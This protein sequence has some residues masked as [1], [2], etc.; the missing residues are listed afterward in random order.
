MKKDMRD[1]QQ[2]RLPFPVC[3]H[4]V[5]ISKKNLGY[6]QG[7]MSDGV[8]FEAEIIH[9]E[10][11]TN[12]SIIIPFNPGQIDERIISEVILDA[13]PLEL[14]YVLTKNMKF[15]GRIDDTDFIIGSLEYIE[16]CGLIAFTGQYHNGYVEYYTDKNGTDLI[17]ISVM[18]EGELGVV[19][20]T[21]L[22][23]IPFR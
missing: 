6:T 14:G 10:N 11:E 7:M 9:D 13:E 1:Y 16:N 8:P 18:L 5:G 17:M 23:F 22:D 21:E 12:L 3:N 15:V 4:M 2:F 20:E 19:C